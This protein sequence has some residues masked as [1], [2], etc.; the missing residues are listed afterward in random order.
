MSDHFRETAMKYPN[1]VALMFEDRQLTFRELD[2]LS[3]R[4]ANVLR[5]TGLGHRDTTAVFMENCLEYLAVY[6]AMSKL[7][8]TG[9]WVGLIKD[10][11]TH[12]SV[13]CHTQTVLLSHWPQLHLSTTIFVRRH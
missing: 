9:E 3:N 10:V 1:K 11:G 12:I 8:V 5:A 7:G 6:L 2:E 13:M 4:I